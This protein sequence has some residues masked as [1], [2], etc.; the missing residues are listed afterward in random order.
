MANVTTN[1]WYVDVRQPEI[2]YLRK[3]GS[4]PDLGTWDTVKQWLE[5]NGTN[6]AN[7]IVNDHQPEVQGQT[8]NPDGYRDNAFEQAK[9]QA[10]DDYNAKHTVNP[11]NP[12]ATPVVLGDPSV[13]TD[14][15]SGKY[16]HK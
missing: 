7:K 16:N 1:K 3:N 10:L 6:W 8:E 14:L 13:W 5:Y 15:A 12:T 2:D 4:E 11:M 9:K